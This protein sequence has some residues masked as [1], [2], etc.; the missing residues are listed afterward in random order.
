MS[1]RV[2]HRCGSDP[3]LLWI[4]PLARELPYATGA[5]LKRQKE[6]EKKERERKPK[7]TS[8]QWNAN[9]HQCLQQNS[10][11]YK[12]R[13]YQVSTRLWANTR[14]PTLLCCWWE[15]NPEQLDWR[16]IWQNRHTSSILKYRVF[17]VP[18]T[19][20]GSPADK[21]MSIHLIYLA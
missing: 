11:N 4:W 13:K 19:E 1:C 8:K 6:R 14:Q 12:V 18:W 5:A 2:G 10:K 20:V 21:P 3:A 15:R 16:A 7:I 17:Y 9:C